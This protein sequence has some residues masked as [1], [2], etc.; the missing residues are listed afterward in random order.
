MS[1]KRP[2]LLLLM[3]QLFWEEPVLNMQGNLFVNLVLSSQLRYGYYPRYSGGRSD[4]TLT[5]SDFY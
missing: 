3:F 4:T 1:K 2:V 5:D